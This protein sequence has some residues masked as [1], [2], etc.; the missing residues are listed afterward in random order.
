MAVVK[1]PDRQ[2][3][4]GDILPP[5]GIP[6]IS[7]PWRLSK[8]LQ[9]WSGAQLH[10]PLGTIIQDVVDGHPIIAQVQVH[11]TYGAHPEWGV[12]PHKGTSIYVPYHVV[13]GK[14][15]AY[16]L[17]PPG[18]TGPE[19]SMG[20]DWEHHWKTR[21]ARKSSFGAESEFAQLADFARKFGQKVVQSS[22]LAPGFR[23]TRASVVS[24][25]V[26]W[27][28][29]L[30]G[31]TDFPYTDAHGLVTI[32]MGNMIDAPAA[33][34]TLGKTCGSGTQIPC[35]SPVPTARARSLPWTGGSLDEGWA[36]LKSSWPKVQSVACRGLTSLRLDQTSIEKL[37]SDQL[38]EN[39][40]TIVSGLRNFGQAPADAQLAAHSM[41]W[42]M[43]PG[44]ASSWTGFR[45][46]FNR[47]DY[48]GAAAQSHMRGVGI[49][50]RN[51]A[52]KLLLLNASAARAAGIDPDKILWLDGLTKLAG[53]VRE[54]TKR[55]G[56]Q[57]RAAEE[58][59]VSFIRKH[60]LET[61][62]AVLG[63][64]LLLMLAMRR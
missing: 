58:G 43:G 38:R 33:G 8:T 44:F 41:A 42:A 32:G 37:I 10:L 48:A 14:R 17:P 24:S 18:W 47:G 20:H 49:D 5:L 19:S 4:F 62:G 50:M 61:V 16:E 3:N 1:K 29:P 6:V 11:D 56:E 9:D 54:A 22:G 31:Y 25:F 64:G 35:G 51:L 63:G 45:D 15:V 36:K 40:Q 23:A 57:A 21:N 7:W 28:K 12:K 13:D 60:P 2:Y 55:A 34:Q 27:S 26:P 59:A 53:G 52:N 46:A 39:E 30:E